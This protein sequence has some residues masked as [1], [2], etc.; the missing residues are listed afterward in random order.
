MIHQIRESGESVVASRISLRTPAAATRLKFVTAGQ[1]PDFV[2]PDFRYTEQC[3]PGRRAPVD[4]EPAGNYFLPRST[5]HDGLRARIISPAAR[6]QLWASW[7]GSLSAWRRHCSPIWRS[8][9][10]SRTLLFSGLICLAGAAV[11]PLACHLHTRPS[12]RPGG[13]TRRRDIQEGSPSAAPGVAADRHD[14]DPVPGHHHPGQRQRRRA[15]GRLLPA[16]WAWCTPAASPRQPSPRRPSRPRMDPGPP[17]QHRPTRPELDPEHP[18]D[19]SAGLHGEVIGCG[20]EPAPWPAAA[21][22]ASR[23]PAR[24]K[25]WYDA[26]PASRDP[27]AQSL[28]PISSPRPGAARYQRA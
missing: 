25:G 10:R 1:G 27:A 9:K 28:L 17:H 22:R 16:A 26:Q 7:D 2:I 4:G 15:R 14:A 3:R 21:S 20:D 24:W 8:G 5:Q 12:G 11:L 13:N 23:D 18:D 19:R 6:S